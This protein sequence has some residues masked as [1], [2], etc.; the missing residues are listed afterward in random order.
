MS[1]GQ[2]GIDVS[3][4]RPMRLQNASDFVERRRNQLVYQTFASTTGANAYLNQTPNAWGSYLN[5]L[6]GRKELFY[7]ASGVDCSACAGLAFAYRE[8]RNFRV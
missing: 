3:G 4:I 8:V 1:A 6:Q 7:L 2:R 5:F